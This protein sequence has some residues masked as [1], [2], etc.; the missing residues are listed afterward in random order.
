[1]VQ[2][3]VCLIK[4]NLH[5]A[6]TISDTSKLFLDSLAKETGYQFEVV[7]IDNLYQGDLSLILVQSGGSERIFKEMFSKLKGPYYLLTYGNNNSL[8]SSLEILSYINEL[9]KDG[10][11]LHGSVS[12]IA[13]RLKEIIAEKSKKAAARLGVIGKPSDWLI[14]SDVDY[15]KARRVFD[16]DLIDLPIKELIDDVNGM[17]FIFKP[18]YFKV[19]Y[20]P[21]ELKKAYS[22]YL[23][24]EKMMKDHQL[25]GLT[26]RCFDLLN[27][28]KTTSCLALSL[29]NAEG[30]IGSCEGD[31]PAMLTSYVIRKALNQPAFQA[32]PAYIDKA[33]NT[34]LF[35]HCTLPLDMAGEYNFDSHFESGIGVA[36]HANMQLGDVTVLKINSHLD[37][38]YCSEGQLLE[39]SY[40]PNLCRTQIKV[41]LDDD[42][43]YFFK[44]PCGN[45]HL[46]C[47]GKNKEKLVKYLTLRGL[48]EIK[49]PLIDS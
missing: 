6:E 48:E 4:S 38:F 23:S 28:I 18:K 5:N 39:N 7:G 45:H 26:I 2:V 19:E 34:V 12:L 44:N 11:I 17:D 3:N 41:R 24:L 43:S 29:I 15:L 42:V 37:H 27:T 14:A 47:Y 20:N 21:E 40:K 16:V 35:A 31:I 9:G 1:M 22:V 32:N 49:Q 25:N 8:A 10:E 46:I 33:D 13:N 30:L 36:I